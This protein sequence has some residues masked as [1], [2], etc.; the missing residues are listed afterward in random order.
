MK[1]A[2]LAPDAACLHL[3]GVSD[4][5]GAILSGQPCAGPGAKF[6]AEAAAIAR[7]GFSAKFSAKFS[8][9]PG[10]GLLDKFRTP[11]AA[12]LGSLLCAL[13][14]GGCATD[15]PV[16][17]ARTVKRPAPAKPAP[18]TRPAPPPMQDASP[19]VAP[20][21]GTAAMP[22]TV[23]D[24]RPRQEPPPGSAAAEWAQLAPYRKAPFQV[25]SLA[26]TQG[27]FKPAPGAVGV[28]VQAANASGPIRL[29]LALR[30]DS[31]VRLAL[32]TYAVQLQLALEYTERRACKAASCNGEI[33]ESLR[34]TSKTVRMVLSPKSGYAAETT[35]PPA[36]LQSGQP[37]RDYDV[38]Y[39]GIVLKVRR[40]SIAQARR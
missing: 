12:L 27:N 34:K 33:E 28:F 40:L 1:T 20:A 36:L 32:G 24:A 8:A 31:P 5:P 9:S 13:L 11:P 26:E 15:E 25:F 29:R 37:D 19:A 39:S 38:S 23:H 17:S 4:G 6:T 21:P 3:T 10:A 22:A 30:P 16:P 14:L 7:A 35:L 18:P 2:H